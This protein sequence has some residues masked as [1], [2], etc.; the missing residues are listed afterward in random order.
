MDAG[1]ARRLQGVD[2]THSRPLQPA[3]PVFSATHWSAEFASAPSASVA[4]L[5]FNGL[6]RTVVDPTAPLPSASLATV[7]RSGAAK[8][9]A[10]LDFGVAADDAD[11]ADGCPPPCSGAAWL[12]VV[13]MRMIRFLFW[14]SRSQLISVP[15]LRRKVAARRHRPARALGLS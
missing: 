3:V 1:G 11:G 6:T 13:V 2:C 5:V 7:R 12:S 9:L 8:L 14:P 15:V 10:A 4:V